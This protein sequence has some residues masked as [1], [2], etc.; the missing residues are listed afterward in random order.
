MPATAG[1]KVVANFLL[2]PQAQLRKADPTVWGDPSV[3]DPAKLTETERQALTPL[4]R[5]IC[6]RC[7]VNRTRPGLTRW[8]RNGCAATARTEAAGLGRRRADLSAA[9]AGR[10]ADGASGAPPRRWQALF[11]DPQFSQALAATLVSTLLSVGALIIT[12]T[13]VA[14]LWPSRLAA[15]GRTALCCWRCPT[16][17]SPPRPAALRRRRLALAPVALFYPAG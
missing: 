13:V 1:A 3:L 14:A 4:C 17:P 16:W 11:A 7:W 12:L 5:R 8:S 6:R 10:C 2:S 15:A 9:A